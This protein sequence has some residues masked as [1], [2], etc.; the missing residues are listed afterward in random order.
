MAEGY[1]ACAF[2]LLNVGDLDVIAQAQQRCDHLTLG[3]FS[4]E[5]VESSSGRPP[6]VPLDERLA[7]VSH[8]RGIEDVVVHEAELAASATDGRI[9]FAVADPTAH[10]PEAMG[11][12]ESTGTTWITPSRI[13]RSPEL[14]DALS[15][16]SP[17]EVAS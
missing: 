17:A 6:V 2:D 13:T 14:L 1:L 16:L 3:V 15:P 10:N 12:C 5:L 7:L 11:R 9:V 4:D 8:L